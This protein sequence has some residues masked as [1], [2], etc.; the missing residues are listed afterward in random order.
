MNAQARVFI[1]ADP[2]TLADA[3]KLALRQTIKTIVLWL[4]VTWILINMMS[5][6]LSFLWPYV[7]F[8]LPHIKRSAA[9]TWERVA[10]VSKIAFLHIVAGCWALAK[11]FWASDLLTKVFFGCS[12]VLILLLVW[13]KRAG[14]DQKLYSIYK[15]E[16]DR[17]QNGYKRL[18]SNITMKSKVAGKYFP[19]VLFSIAVLLSLKFFGENIAVVSRSWMYPIG[20]IILPIGRV[21]YQ[22][23]DRVR[24]QMTISVFWLHYFIA[25]NALALIEEFPFLQKVPLFS[26][27]RCFYAFWLMFP[28]CH[29]GTIV[30]FALARLNQNNHIVD[31]PLLTQFMGIL[32]LV[33]SALGFSQSVVQI[34]EGGLVQLATAF[35]GISMPYYAN[36]LLGIVY[37]MYA[38]LTLV[39]L[40][41]N[42]KASGEDKEAQHHLVLFWL[43]Y[44]ITFQTVQQFI[45]LELPGLL[46]WIPFVGWIWKLLRLL[47]LLWL[48]LPGFRGAD[49][50]YS[51]FEKP[52][53][54]IPWLKARVGIILRIVL[55]WWT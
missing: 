18:H 9:W 29:G 19:H 24:E 31:S 6:G 7:N 55:R 45:P 16:K 17:L 13:A 36:I 25:L 2:Q 23:A 20:A 1:H 30:C 43:R 27:F 53:T 11:M 15:L 26:E 38:S 32:R 5:R 52:K 22:R 3:T 14:F 12:L 42:N 48:Q 54:F 8:I 51:F 35:L 47:F 50:I 10:F 49:T 4:Q 34:L 37:P 44:F 46:E 33:I 39:N 28:W 40:M 21:R 41:N